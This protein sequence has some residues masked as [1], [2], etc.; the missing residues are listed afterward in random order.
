MRRVQKEFALQKAISRYPA[1]R[2]TAY[3]DAVSEAG[4]Y[5]P[6][7]W[8]DPLLA[9]IFVLGLDWREGTVLLVA[10]GRLDGTGKPCRLDEPG[11]WVLLNG[12]RHYLEDIG[13]ALL[14]SDDLSSNLAG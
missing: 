14:L 3:L 7:V 11:Y 1:V 2:M 5:A 8:A 10:E 13:L 12:D 4:E 9:Q 6:E